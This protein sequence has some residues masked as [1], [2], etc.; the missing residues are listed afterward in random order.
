ML[1]DLLK[2]RPDWADAHALL[3]RVRLM[4]DDPVGAEGPLR[5]GIAINPGFAAARADLGWAL[6]RLGRPAEAD[7]EF[8]RALE[9]DPLDALP[10]QQLAWREWLVTQR[11]D[12]GR[13]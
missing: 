10:R 12:P 13:P 11:D 2:S 3:G 7:E 5:A 9:L 4:R 1:G 6:L 8:V